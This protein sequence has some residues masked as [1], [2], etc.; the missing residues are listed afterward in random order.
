[1]VPKSDIRRVNAMSKTSKIGQR[2]RPDRMDAARAVV[3]F[4]SD[5]FPVILSPLRIG[6]CS[7]PI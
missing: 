2:P 4:A 5:S 3:S 6:D 1:M 7:N